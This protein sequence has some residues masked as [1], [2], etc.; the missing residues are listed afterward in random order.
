MDTK[1]KRNRLIGVLVVLC[2]CL[3]PSIFLLVSFESKR[4]KAFPGSSWG[5]IEEI[6]VAFILGLI[7][8][9]II[10][11]AVMLE[12]AIEGALKTGST[13]FPDLDYNLR[14]KKHSVQEYFSS[15]APRFLDKKIVSKMWDAVFPPFVRTILLCIVPLTVVMVGGL[16]FM[17]LGFCKNDLTMIREETAICKG[18]VT[19]IE[20]KSSR[21]GVSFSFDYEYRLDSHYNYSS[22][23]KSGI[24]KGKSFTGKKIYEKGDV[25]PVE[26]L[27][28][29]PVISRIKGMRASP[30]DPLLPAIVAGLLVFVLIPFLLIHVTLQKRF[31][32][33]LVVNGSL[34]QGHIV[35]VKKGGKGMVFCKVGYEFNGE[36]YVQRL[37]CPATK[38]L[39]YPLSARHEQKIPV[40]LL[41][42][43][44]LVRK[45]YLFEMHFANNE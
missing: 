28:A 14:L 25:V 21:S 35:S 16:L 13:V 33:T 22:D 39:Y 18:Y 43:P 29:D 44:P 26:Y 42:S 5:S 19:H 2:L 3:F 32:K 20:K 12:K 40:T 36:E 41:V 17:V 4:E 38:G 7:V 31:L 8:I 24:M 30:L 45:S 34:V 9:S 1:K 23:D 37:V 6:T 27:L 11:V 15:P 10:V